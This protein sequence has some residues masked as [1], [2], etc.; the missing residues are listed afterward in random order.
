MKNDSYECTDELPAGWE[1]HEGT[2]NYSWVYK[3]IIIIFFLIPS[4]KFKF[5]F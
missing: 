3:L 2:L 5:K 1:K 4:R